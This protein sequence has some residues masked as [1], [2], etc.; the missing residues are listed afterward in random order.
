MFTR[1]LA[2]L[3]L[4]SACGKPPRAAEADAPP[5]HVATTQ[6]EEDA[7]DER[8][9]VEYLRMVVPPSEGEDEAATR[10]RA[11]TVVGLL[12]QPGTSF[13]ETAQSYGAGDANRVRMTRAE[14]R[15]ST[16]GQAV[17]RLRV[18][19]T[20]CAASHGRGLRHR[21]APGR[22]AAGATEH[23]GSPHPRHAR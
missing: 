9:N 15:D 21:P 1:V 8:E 6:G 2:C 11:E 14:A 22:S 19:Q 20:R 13:L 23:R 4:L 10:A 5:L 17:L 16:I 7:G 3:A 18:G 12:R